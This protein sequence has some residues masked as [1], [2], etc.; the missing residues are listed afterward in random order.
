MKVNIGDKVITI[1]GYI[2]RII[3]IQGN[4]YVVEVDI[5]Q[6]FFCEESEVTLYEG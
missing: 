1:Q 3:E 4:K 2:G 5:P 6:I